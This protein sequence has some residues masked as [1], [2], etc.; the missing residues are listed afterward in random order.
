[1]PIQARKQGSIKRIASKYIGARMMI[2][3]ILFL[4]ASIAIA[5][6]AWGIFQ[7]FGIYTFTI[8]LVISIALLLSRIGKPKFKNKDK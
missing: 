2:Q 5:G 6:L 8:M 1:M 7:I 3:N 4:V